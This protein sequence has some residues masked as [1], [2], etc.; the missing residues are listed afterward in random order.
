MAEEK[1]PQRKQ[2]RPRAQK[3]VY[4]GRFAD[5]EHLHDEIADIVAVGGD[6]NTACRELGLGASTVRSALNPNSKSFCPSFLEKYNEAKQEWT[7]QLKVEATRRA[8]E[9]YE[10]SVFFQGVEVGK[11]RKYSDTLLLALLKASSPEFRDRT[12][13]VN[14]N[15]N[16]DLNELADMTSEQRDQLEQ[17]LRSMGAGEADDEA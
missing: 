3:E 5:Q 16:V 2:P 11:Q 17:L 7:Q 10:E 12:E 4:I 6:I 9:G 8:V 14:I 15:G 1:K 13:V